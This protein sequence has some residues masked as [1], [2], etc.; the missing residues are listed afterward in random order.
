MERTMT[1]NQVEQ[2]E[3]KNNSH[4]FSLSEEIKR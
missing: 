1:K 2:E 3:K 4:R